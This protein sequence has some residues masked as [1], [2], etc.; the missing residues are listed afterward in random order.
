MLS[1]TYLFIMIEEM[2]M[3]QGAFDILIYLFQNLFI[4]KESVPL[5]PLRSAQRLNSKLRGGSQIIRLHDH[6]VQHGL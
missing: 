3:R 2:Q 5:T 4:F 6:L 1:I